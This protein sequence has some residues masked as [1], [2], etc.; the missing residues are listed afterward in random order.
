MTLR[1]MER[2]QKGS[3]A[4]RRANYSRPWLQI[5]TLCMWYITPFA[6]IHTQAVCRGRKIYT[7]RSLRTFITAGRQSSY[8]ERSVC[9][10]RSGCLPVLQMLFILSDERLSDVTR[11]S[12][13]QISLSFD[14]VDLRI[15]S[16]EQILYVLQIYIYIILVKLFHPSSKLKFEKP[17][18][19]NAGHTYIH[20][21][22][23]WDF[24]EKVFR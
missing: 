16:A 11:F 10:C 18:L 1:G 17:W 14:V 8:S 21:T 6:S 7:Q 20:D 24:K 4:L 19:Q 12:Q 2:R 15:Q 23:Y 3:G 22:Y 13:I 5:H 9:A